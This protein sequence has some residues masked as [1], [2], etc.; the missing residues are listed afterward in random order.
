MTVPLPQWLDLEW[1]LT[2]LQAPP[3]FQQLGMMNLGPRFDQALLRARKRAT[4]TLDRVQR[5]RRDRVLVRRMKMRPMVRGTN[6][7]EHANDDS[8]E[9]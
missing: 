7:R 3:V 9:S 8:E 2:G 6:F 1:W 4:Y 5:K